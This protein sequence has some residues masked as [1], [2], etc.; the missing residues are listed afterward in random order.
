MLKRFDVII[1]GAGASGALVAANL[2]RAASAPARFALIG[3]DGDAGRGLA[4]GT[5]CE[6][7]LLNVPVRGMSAFADDPDDFVR[8]IGGRQP[9]VRPGDF[10]ARRTYG[11]YI[12]DVLASAEE[13]G[14]RS[15][16]T[17][18]R[19]NDRAI[20]SRLTPSRDS[21]V[22]G[23]AGGGSVFGR[24]IVL[25]LGNFAPAPIRGVPSKIRED[26]AYIN[27]PWAPGALDDVPIDGRVLLV[28]TGLTMYDV[29]LG[30]HREGLG[31]RSVAISRRGLRP[32]V[33]VDRAPPPIHE[34]PSSLN[35]IARA[36]AHADADGD[37]WRAKIDAVR[38]LT[39]GLW[40]DLP[41][42]EREEFLRV[43]RRAWDVRRH[44]A[45]PHVDKAIRRHEAR[46]HLEF[47]A[48]EIAGVERSGR[49]LLVELGGREPGVLTVDRIVNCTG[50]QSDY[51][52]LSDP[53]VSDLRDQGTLTP[54][55]LGLGLETDG[56]SALIDPNGVPSTVYYSVGPPTKPMLWEITAIPEIRQ[57]AAAL[58][59]RLLEQVAPDQAPVLV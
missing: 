42:G 46:R 58:A 34:K 12:E 14:A 47:R 17:L 22:V 36:V 28:G 41:V 32:E 13:I 21:A 43:W 48:A 11:D 56:S 2:L 31:P 27:D 9:S 19:V 26:S 23:L 7:H 57:Q 25:A 38:P 4:Y 10:V 40:R 55:P 15:D 44:R 33:H 52:S 37:D 39:P 30:L 49:R 29:F 59:F 50:P 3:S 51:R 16:A 1:V 45:A 35:D 24:R 5:T 53:L 8:W 6:D 54:C 18:T 20:A